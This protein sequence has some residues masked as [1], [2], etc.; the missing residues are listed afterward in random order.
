LRKPL[1]SYPLLCLCDVY[2]LRDSPTE[3]LFA[4]LVSLYSYIPS[5]LYPPPP[6]YRYSFISLCYKS[7]SLRQMVCNV[8]CFCHQFFDPLKSPS[9]RV[10]TYVFVLFLNCVRACLLR[11]FTIWDAVCSYTYILLS[12]GLSA[13]SFHC[14]RRFMFVLF[15]RIHNPKFGFVV[16]DLSCFL[17]LF[18]LS[19]KERDHS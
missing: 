1:T 18:R 15:P 9:R 12:Q 16:R 13:F 17:T 19:L 6:L 8:K 14:C 4:F 10:I 11:R 3:V 2:L 5:P 7:S